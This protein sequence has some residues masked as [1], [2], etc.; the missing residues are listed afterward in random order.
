MKSEV[1]KLIKNLDRIADLLYKGKISEA[2]SLVYNTEGLARDLRDSQ[3][4]NRD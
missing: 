2:K 3:L 4:K 1:D